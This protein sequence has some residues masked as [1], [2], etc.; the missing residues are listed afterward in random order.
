MAIA[1][2]TVDDGGAPLVLDDVLGWSDQSR[3]HR[4]LGD[5]ARDQQEIV[6]TSR[7]ERYAKVPGVDEPVRL[8]AS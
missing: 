5:A 7:W 2:L 3:L 8:G 1:R 6:L 4:L